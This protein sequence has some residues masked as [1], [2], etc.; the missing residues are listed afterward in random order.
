MKTHQLAVLLL[1]VLILVSFALAGEESTRNGVVYVTNS[2]PSQGTEK[3]QLREMWRIGGD[4]ESVIFGSIDKVLL[5]RDGDLYILDGKASLVL[6][7]SLADGRELRQISI[8]GEGPGELDFASNMFLVGDDQIAL[9]RSSPAK[10]VCINYQGLPGD[11]VD[12]SSGTA[13]M[14]LTWYADWENGVLV[15]GGQ[16]PIE[17]QTFLAQY[18]YY[19][20][21]RRY[22][23]Y[24]SRSSF[25]QK[26]MAEEDAY[27]V[28]SKPWAID[29]RGDVYFAPSWTNPESGSYSINV[30]DK[31][32]RLKRVFSRKFEA[33]RRSSDEKKVAQQKL[34]GGSRGLQDLLDQGGQCLVNDYAQDVLEVY[35]HHDGNIWVHTSRSVSGQSAGTMITYDVFSPTGHFIKQVSLLSSGNAEKDIV[36]FVG[37]DRLVLVKGQT[38]VLNYG[39]YQNA[40]ALEIICY[41]TK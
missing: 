37:P 4:D 34:L 7:C 1:V 10:V 39:V 3:I 2:I 25:Q 21:L 38:D 41:S 9:L 14:F 11:R 35:V 19:G 28:L 17:G 33:S 29:S 6:V 20:E 40:D 30:Y 12:I 31:D 22:F 23:S 15:M 27:L 8:S 13:E 32:A 5:G 26:K 16:N 18:A 24:A 36:Y